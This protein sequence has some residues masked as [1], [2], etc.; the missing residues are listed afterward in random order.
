MTSM[1]AFKSLVTPNIFD[2]Y[3]NPNLL[4]YLVASNLLSPATWE[5]SEKIQ[6]RALKACAAE[7]GASRSSI[8]EIQKV[9]DRSF[10]HL[11]VMQVAELYGELDLADERARLGEACVNQ[12]LDRILRTFESRIRSGDIPAEALQPVIDRAAAGRF[13]AYIYGTI[14]LV[15]ARRKLTG[16]SHA[17]IKGVTSCVDETAIFAAL[18]TTLKK[19]A[20]AN[21]IALSSPSHTTA[22][23]WTCEGEP[24]WFYG[25]N[26]IYFPDTWRSVVAQSRSA[27][28]QSVFDGWLGD[29]N[30]I[31]SVAGTFDLETGQSNLPAAHIEEIA[32]HME[33]FFGVRLRQVE[34]GLSKPRSV[35]P[36]DP[37]A[38]C[39]RGL[40]GA[41]S[42]EMA[43]EILASAVDVAA[44][45]V[46]YAFRSLS[47]RDLR[48]Y[49]EVAREQPN[50][51]SLAH[52]LSSLEEVLGFVRDLDG[53]GSI[54]G[55]R[56]RIAMP[57]ETLSFRLGTDRDKALLLHALLE[58]LGPRG[59]VHEPVVTCFGATRSFVRTGSR[60]FDAALGAP[61][62]EPCEPILLQLP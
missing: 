43:R 31:T 7:G 14:D 5:L 17:S 60:W 59:G 46:L 55:S 39:L 49:L 12:A 35:W 25:K 56:D 37:L 51:R 45:G 54:F 33:T 9:L 40:M 26:R 58:H 16:F 20:V 30:R 41:T 52:S 32:S 4:L 15:R 22:F 18:A 23:G 10:R 44:Q 2:A 48:P 11:H 19:G 13:P 42:L 29:L 6:Q 3:A 36:E 28:P 50:C 57:D 8:G 38:D 53:A 34:A 61:V 24:W 27:N 21:V 62:L 47:V 1:L